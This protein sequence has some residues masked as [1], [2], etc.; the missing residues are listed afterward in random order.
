VPSPQEFRQIEKEND[1]LKKILGEKD[2]EIAILR[3]LA[4]KA[5]P[6]FQTGLR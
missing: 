5:R 2:L 4:K 3:D 1:Q 6:G